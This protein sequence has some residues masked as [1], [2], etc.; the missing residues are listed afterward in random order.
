LLKGFNIFPKG[1]NIS[2]IRNM[3]MAYLRN[4]A[5]ADGSFNVA[6]VDDVQQDKRLQFKFK[7]AIKVA[8]FKLPEGSEYYKK[9]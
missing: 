1:L 2:L 7:D 5:Y 4:A 9:R 6:I 3:G 8:Y